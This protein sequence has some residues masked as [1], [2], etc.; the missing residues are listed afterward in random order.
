MRKDQRISFLPGLGFVVGGS[1]GVVSLAE[2]SG[3]ASW[4]KRCSNKSLMIQ[5]ANKA[6]D[7]VG[8]ALLAEETA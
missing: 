5:R 2:K 4:R 8:K 7:G 1:W 6:Q 3:K